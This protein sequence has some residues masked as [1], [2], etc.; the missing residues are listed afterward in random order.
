MGLKSGDNG[1][2][3][4]F[5][6]QFASAFLAC[7]RLDDVRELV[8]VARSETLAVLD[9]NVMVKG[10]PQSA[11][12]F[13][14][15][16][17]ILVAQIAPAIE[18]AAHVVIVFDEPRAMTRAKLETQKSRDAKSQA[19]TPMCSE[20]LVACITTDEFTEEMLH[21]DGC[22]VRMLMDHRAARPRFYDA[23]CGAILAH[24]VENTSG[25]AAWSLTFDGV[26][27]RG[28]ER[29]FD[30][31]RRAGILSSDDEFWRGLLHRQ[32]PIGEGDLKLTDVAQRVHDA[33]KY[34]STPVHGVV[35]NLLVTIDTDSL[36]IEL[37]KQQARLARTDESDRNE[38]SIV[39]L[40]EPAR[41]RK[42]DDFVTPARFL[43]CNAARFHADVAEYLAP[44][45]SEDRDA[46]VALLVAACACCGC[47]F[48]EVKGARADLMLPVVKDVVRRHPEVLRDMARVFAKEQAT[49]REAKPAIDTVLKAYA[50]DIATKPRMKR[51]HASAS[52][53]CDAQVLRALWTVSYWCGREFLDCA[54]WG[55]AS[56]SV[57]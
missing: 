14:E 41:K 49:V 19:Q 5:Q 17:Q 4:V 20:E 18:A 42:G 21:A 13:R 29:A 6:T 11:T 32:T 26:D 48:L 23:L 12:T 10:M 16:V 24:F 39:C 25:D 50:E 3:A 52:N 36:V 43:C 33:A 45:R 37:L 51:S 40:K 47:D 38:L 15:Y 27:P 30:A 46:A 2:K 28:I 7:P 31:P 34:P 53:Y 1:C 56:E 57:A 8:G 9:G 55:F 22:N 54:D 44:A 35:L